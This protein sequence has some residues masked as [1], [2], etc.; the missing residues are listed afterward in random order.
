M[1]TT[2]DALLEP[3]IH[4][5]VSMGEYLALPYMNASGLEELRRSVLH[6]RHSLTD[7]REKTD[8]LVRGEALHMALLEPLLFG[9]YYVVPEPCTQEL[10]SG[11]REGEPCGNPGVLLHEDVGWLCGV[12]ARGFG[13][14]IREDVEV[15]SPQLH[16]DVVGMRD[17]IRS[18]PRASTFFDGLGDY[19]V[20]VVFDDPETG[21]RCKIRPDRLVER[22]GMHVMLKSTRDAAPWAFPNDAERRGYFRSAALY[23]RGLRAVGWPY[24]ATTILAVENVAP[25]DLIPYLI[26]EDQDLD[27]ADREVSRLLRQYKTA[28]TADTWPG[29]ADDFQPIRRPTWARDDFEFEEGDDDE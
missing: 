4:E 2:T 9:G 11:K 6:Y 18:H 19:E 21:V 17:S 27:G 1:T 15:L 20:T 14:G 24:Q 29:Y 12:H 3:G 28:E 26:D 13:G 7:E 5:G 22:A 16:A 23:R 25:Y 10:K 8:A